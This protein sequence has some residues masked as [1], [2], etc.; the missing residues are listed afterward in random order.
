MA[1]NDCAL[2]VVNAIAPEH[3]EIHKE[4]PEG[5]TRGV[6]NAGAIFLGSNTAEAFGDYIAG[7]SHVLPTGGTARFFSPLTTQSFSKFS[8]V[9]QMSKKGVDELGSYARIIAELEGLYS[10]ARSIEFRER[11]RR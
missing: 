7:P 4:N 6:I 3:L 8:S 11:E 10:H 1:N 2:A 5:F 9:V